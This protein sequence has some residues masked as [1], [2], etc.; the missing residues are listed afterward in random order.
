MDI[1]GEL[2]GVP[3]HQRFLIVAYDLY[4]KWPEAVSTGSVTTQAVIDFLEVLFARWGM[5]TTITTDNGPQFISAEFTTFLSERG[6]RHI[7]TAFYNPHR[8]KHPAFTI[9]DWVRVRRPTRGH[10]LLSFWSA[11][12]QVTEQLGPATFRLSDGTRWHA[13]R[14][15]KVATPTAADLEA[16]RDPDP[17]SGGPVNPAARPV[18]SRAKP[19]YLRNY[20]V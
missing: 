8:A 2:R 4:S 6:I 3:H 16:S 1:C 20:Y 13:R 7:R 19:G 10:K 14:L 9:L 15:R 17:D 18:R 12:F 11:P 5:P